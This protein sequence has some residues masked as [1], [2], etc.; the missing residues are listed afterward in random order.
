MVIIQ[1]LIP[2]P[3][4][5]NIGSLNLS[6]LKGL[7][8]LMASFVSASIPLSS[9]SFFLICRFDYKQH[10]FSVGRVKLDGLG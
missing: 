3:V 8:N 2:F 7:V 1:P 10:V 5:Y 6:L 4:R 9:H